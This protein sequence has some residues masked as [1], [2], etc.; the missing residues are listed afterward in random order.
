MKSRLTILLLT[1]LIILTLTGLGYAL[2]DWQVRRSYDLQ[3]ATPLDVELSARGKWVF[4]LTD[5][6]EILVYTSGGTLRD[7]IKVGEAIDGI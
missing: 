1:S 7:T 4:V 2:T 5:K 6:G 3:G